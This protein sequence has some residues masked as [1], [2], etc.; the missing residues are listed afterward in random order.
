VGDEPSDELLQALIPLDGVAG[1]LERI[2]E[3]FVAGADHVA[4]MPLPTA[5]DP[6][7]ALESFAARLQS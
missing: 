2:R 3:H 7:P 6:F 4:I 1:S 5:N